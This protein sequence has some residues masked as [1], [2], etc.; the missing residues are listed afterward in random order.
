MSPETEK[1]LESEST[2]LLEKVRTVLTDAHE[3]EVMYNILPGP[4]T[5]VED[6]ALI[7]AFH[8]PDVADPRNHPSP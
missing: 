6:I 5:T 1:K 7:Q 2:T 3:P 4:V 8:G